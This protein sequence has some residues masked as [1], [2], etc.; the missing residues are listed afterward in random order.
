MAFNI[1]VADDS[2]TMRA[3]IKKTVR[4]SGV[5]VGDFYEAGNGLEALAVLAEN[6][7]DVILSDI[8]MPDMDGVALLKKINEDDDLKRIPLIFITTEASEARM[9]EARR[10]GAA[11]YV[12]KPFHPELIKGVLLE[13]LD[14]AYAHKPGSE[15]VENAGE[16]H[17]F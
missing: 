12:K 6:W 9:G 10:L 7:V 16:G 1:L 5:P 3:V 14:K 8:N 15:P 13:V 2:E 11:G 4:M 17:D